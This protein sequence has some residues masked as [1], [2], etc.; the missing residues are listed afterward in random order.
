[1]ACSGP[2]FNPNPAAKINKIKYP[3]LLFH[4][5]KIFPI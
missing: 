5:P 3:F 4:P 1:M 2:V